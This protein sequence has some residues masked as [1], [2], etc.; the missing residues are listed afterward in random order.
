MATVNQIYAL[1]NDSVAEALGAEAIDVKDTASFVTAASKVLSSNDYKD[2]FLSAL[3]DRIG[4]TAIAIRAVKKKRRSIKRDELEW[5][6]VYQKISFKTADASKNTAWDPE[7][8]GNPFTVTSQGGVVQALFTV[9]STYHYEDVIPDYQLFTAFTSAE[10]M[11]AFIS[12]IYQRMEND[13]TRSENAL[14]DTA[15][16]TNIAGV[17]LKGGDPQKRNLLGE[18]ITLSGKT[19]TAI[20][21]AHMDADYLKYATREIREI[22]GNLQEDSVIYNVSEDIPR[23]TPSDKMVVEVLNKFASAVSSYLE[24]DTYH[25]EMVSLPG[26]EEVRYWQAPGTSFA[27]EDVSKINI[28]NANLKVTGNNTGSCEQGGIIAFVHDI[29]SCACIMNRVRDHSIPDQYNERTVIIKNA[30]PGFLVD[31]TENAVVFYE[32]LPVVPDEPGEVGGGT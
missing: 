3:V 10:R 12:G 21:D 15:V 1:V 19:Y 17:L 20:E 23:N 4:R 16:A 32:E 25:N 30:D 13:F 11:G 14:A 22:T 27:F 9:L 6:A 7:H 28:K 26:Y 24:S 18:F 31:L 5:G 29:D 2:A 8:P